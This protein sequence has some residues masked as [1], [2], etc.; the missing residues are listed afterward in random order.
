MKVLSGMLSLSHG[1]TALQLPQKWLYAIRDESLEQCLRE[2]GSERHWQRDLE[3]KGKDGVP[4]L[5]V[6]ASR[7]DDYFRVVILL[8]SEYRKI[9]EE[10]EAGGRCS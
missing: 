2:E 4:D 5:V 7:D 6:W 1:V 10:K 9:V 8:E 3:G